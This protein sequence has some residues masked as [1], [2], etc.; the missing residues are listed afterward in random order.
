VCIVGTLVENRDRETRERDGRSGTEQTSEALRAQAFRQQ[1]EGD[2]E[3]ASGEALDDQNEDVV[4]R[5]VLPG[6]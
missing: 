2:N 4:D 5:A 6:C 3:R 1:R